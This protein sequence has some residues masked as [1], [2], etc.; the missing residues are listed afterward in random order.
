M[1]HKLL[2]RALIVFAMGAV[3]Q[4][5]VPSARASAGPVNCGFCELGCPADVVSFCHTLCPGSTEGG[6]AVASCSNG[7]GYQYSN[8]VVCY[9]E[10]QT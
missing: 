4:F 1:R 7:D 9:N 6:C 10:Q 8:A 5:T 3:A 2:I